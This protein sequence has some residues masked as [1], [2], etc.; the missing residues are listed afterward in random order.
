M[1]EVVI[2]LDI[3]TSSVKAAGFDRNGLLLGKASE[4]VAL[5]SPK[6]GWFEQEPGDWWNAACKVLNQLLTVIDPAQVIALGLSGQCPGHVLTGSDQ[7]PIGRAIIWRDQRAQAESVWLEKH[8]PAEQAIRW[9]GTAF[10]Q[11]ATCPPARLLW[12]K[13]N[14]PADWKLTRAVLQPKD[15]ISLKLT[16]KT[17]TDRYS[18]YCLVS[19]VSGIYETDYFAAL[20]LPVDKMPAIFKMTGV[21]GE[22]SKI[23]GG[24]TGLKDGTPVVIGTIDAYCDNLAGG[25]TRPQC[26][27]DVA[28]TSEI[29]S[30]A[31][32][33]GAA[34]EGI[35]PASLEE[36]I[37]FVCGPT[38]A[39]G[40]TLHWLATS[41][42]AENS[43]PVNYGKMESEAGLA[44]AGS[45]GL[46]FLPYLNG[47]RSPIW[48]PQA[49]GAF[50]G[51]T[52]HHD[53]RHFTRAVYESIGFAIRHILELAEKAA[54][55]KAR[56]L[57]TCGGGSR[58]AFW[59]QVKA[60]VL[61]VPVR[62][63]AV[64]ETGCLG[65]A[66]LA[67]AGA[68]IH[69]TIRQA[70][71]R[72]VSFLTPVEPDQRNAGTYETGYQAYR[73]YYPAIRSTQPG[74]VH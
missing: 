40:D 24:H 41:F 8:I 62:P 25:V 39:G 44:P 19:P 58:S 43:R 66:M 64:S 54:H 47:E 22:V 10:L 38:Q 72:M 73:R 63:A 17:G 68:G 2:G 16:G 3:G 14:R 70:C 59:N 31:A 34:G 29:I 20:G 12:L 46:V 37:T 71:D 26:A 74:A 32:E 48:D 36:G 56:E 7:E 60:D 53:R 11:D 67:S 1:K 4:P 55:S 65:A 51:L 6:P 23:A 27:V 28:G 15:F 5:H 18:A 35:F 33:A 45:D 49:R 21:I 42:Y 50:L 57:V 30:M 9:T 13:K 61:Q 52:F 69:P